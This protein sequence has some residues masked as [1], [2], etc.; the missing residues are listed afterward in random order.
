MS[1]Q[2]SPQETTG[3]TDTGTNSAPETVAIEGDL[4]LT[5][6][7]IESQKD[8]MSGRYHPIRGFSKWFAA[9]PTP[10]VRLAI[11]GSVYP[12]EIDHDELLR[13]MQ[14]G[15]KSRKED[16]S[17]FVKEKFSKMSQNKGSGTL[18]DYYGYPNPNT[19][20]PTAAQLDRLHETTR[21][22][23]GGEVPTI[24]DPTAG[25]GIIPFEA[26]R[27][28]FPAVS[29][30]LD[31]IPSVINK[32]ALEY[33]PE[34]GSVKPDID[35]WKRKIKEQTRERISEYFPTKEP[36]REVLNYAMTYTVT[37]DSCGG[38]I[39]LTGKWWLNKTSSGGDAVRPH[40]QD[41]QVSYEHLKVENHSDFD[42]SDAPVSRG[43]DA[44]CPH[45]SVA[46]DAETIREKFRED[47]FQ[48]SVYGV[49]YETSNGDWKF[50][51]GSEIDQE[52]LE[53]AA[54]RVES[55]FEMLDFFSEAIPRGKE[56]ERLPKW[57]ME[58]W[59]DLFTPRQLVVNY[60]LFQTFERCKQGIH[61]EE[62]DNKA[63]LMIALL[64]Q[65][66][67][68][69]IQFNSR[70]S[71]WRDKKGYVNEIFS[72]QDYSVKR[73]IGSNNVCASRR[74]LDRHFEHV[75]DEYYEELASYVSGN[76][77]PCELYN[78]DAANLTDKAAENSVE[79]AVV[80]PPYFDSIMYGELSD[81]MY[82]T[83]RRLLKSEF[84]DLFETELSN[85]ESQA[86]VNDERHG[87]P[88]EFYE[89]KMKDI[90]QEVKSALVP[91]GVLMLMFTDREVKAWNTIVKSV[92]E[93][94]FTI[95]ASHPIK[96]EMND[97]IG[98][99]EKA[100]VQSSI[101]L[102]ARNRSNEGEI[103]TWEDIEDD[104]EK[105]AREDAQRLLSIE[106][107]DKVDTSIAAFGPALEKYSEAYPVEDKYGDEVEPERVLAKARQEVTEVIANDEISTDTDPVDGLTRWY[108]LSLTQYGEANIPFDEA[109]QL[110]MGS[111]VEITKIK[112]PTKIWSKSSGDVSLNNHTGRVQDIVK[113]RDD[114]TENPSSR[115]YPVN[116]TET[117]FTY[118]IDAVH[119]ALHVYEREG[120]QFT[121]DWLAER[122]FKSDKAFTTTVKALLEAV[123]SG[124]QMH[125]T[126]TD[127][128]SGDTGDYL[129]ISVSN[130][131]IT[132]DDG[133]QSG[134]G[135]FE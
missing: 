98:M 41:G 32:I 24:L 1:E 2:D 49:N 74:G 67:D 42:P 84:P 15:K 125:D 107:I 89:A 111:D 27:Y 45:C 116:P 4:P 55:D 91:D 87:S 134:L 25:R 6:I 31:P 79:A 43:G 39:P 46:M 96:T 135:E 109:N 50:R 103:T 68:R 85:K 29:N 126:L 28:G 60:E 34:V 18:D 65:A 17:G 123:P 100:N 20:N 61:E 53:K 117:T 62:N 23:W 92:I 108:I 76:T 122:G 77:T 94:G 113:L 97:K 88:E 118:A 8:M 47:E 112:T 12:G 66:I 78:G 48:Y 36:D 132:D 95:T 72:N 110:G 64:A 52:G 104:I 127:L 90:F 102:V 56:T 115:K 81:F 124:N 133:D 119:A 114:R 57:G 3:S 35:E 73:M 13:L 129:D 71:P 26:L 130:L 120:S 82:I 30:E 69:Q 19:Q 22:A 80:D 7:D 9:R 16:I 5:A 21:E 83:Q 51:A 99:V 70:L 37:C 14:V 40:Y 58:Q 38:D 131:N 10:A 105:T 106:D 63:K 128:V 44:E 33:A 93:S 11:L 121:R 75:I 59:Q 101:F 54:E 86:V